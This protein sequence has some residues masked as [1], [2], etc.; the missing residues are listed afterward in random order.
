M[1]EHPISNNPPPPSLPLP[2][3]NWSLPPPSPAPSPPLPPKKKAAKLEPTGIAPLRALLQPPKLPEPTDQNAWGLR[4]Q[5]TPGKAASWCVAAFWPQNLQTLD[6]ALPPKRHGWK[7][8]QGRALRM[9]SALT[10]VKADD[11]ICGQV[12][13]K[14]NVPS[15]ADPSLKSVMSEPLDECRPLLALLRTGSVRMS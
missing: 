8:K 1:H 6:G 10:L 4:P 15:P 2:Q 3:R 14:H 13:W 7:W 11:M 12:T 5:R 9:A